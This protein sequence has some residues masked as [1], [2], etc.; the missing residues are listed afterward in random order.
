MVLVSP[1][2]P[3]GNGAVVLLSLDTG[4]R[5]ELTAPAPYADSLPAVSPDGEHIAFIRSLTLSTR[6]VFV[7]PTR[8]GPARRITYGQ[9]PVFGVT[10][11]SDSR[12][13][14]FSSNRG[15]GE[16]LWRVRASGG[17]PERVLIG[18]Q[19]VFY[20]NI[21]RKGDRL[22]FTEDFLDTNV[23]R[24]NGPGFVNRDTPGRF[25]NPERLIDSSREDASPAFSPDGQRIAFVSKRTGSEEISV[26]DRNGG[27]LVQATSFFGPAT[28][29]PRSSP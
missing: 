17:R 5:R 23:Y 13:V 9:R 7:V 25:S 10:W 18:L 2:P 22:I 12:N 19:S 4:E 21:S 3:E 28:G 24:F 11:T 14:V 29:T 8:G 20:P 6:E 1:P 27:H 26:C 16:S 15:G